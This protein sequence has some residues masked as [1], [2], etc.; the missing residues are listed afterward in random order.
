MGRN[1]RRVGVKFCGNCQPRRDMSALYRAL[2]RQAGDL[3]FV[4]WSDPADILLILQACDT[5]CATIPPFAGPR[6][7]VVASRL[8]FVEYEDDAAL[9]AAVL[10][11]LRREA[12]K[13][14]PPEKK[15]DR[16]NKS[17]LNRCG[18]SA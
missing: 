11:A 16:F 18:F 7:E 10:A 17:G 5:A 3:A 1:S 15:Q 13:L 14:E 4:R 9:L 2:Q 12:K 8:D 6:V